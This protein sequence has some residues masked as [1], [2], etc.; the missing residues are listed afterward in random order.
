VSECQEL[1][2]HEERTGSS[3]DD[4]PEARRDAASMSLE[5]RTGGIPSYPRSTPQTDSTL[6]GV[7][8]SH[9]VGGYKLY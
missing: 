1:Q 9:D 6:Q 7:G 4:A 8:G 5:G 3:H 2:K